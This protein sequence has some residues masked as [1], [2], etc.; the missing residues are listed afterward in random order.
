MGLVILNFGNQII[1]CLSLGL[2]STFLSSSIVLL[3]YILRCALLFSRYYIYLSLN[4]SRST[5]HFLCELDCLLG[6]FSLNL[7]IPV[8][9]VVP[10]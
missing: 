8:T 1:M 7:P 5:L 6:K 2:P 3:R 9:P 4:I 10:N